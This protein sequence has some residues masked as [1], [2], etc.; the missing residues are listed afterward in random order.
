MALQPPYVVS[1]SRRT[2]VAAC[3]TEWLAEALRAG[4]VNVHSP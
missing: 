1:C 4:V 3:Y 2:D